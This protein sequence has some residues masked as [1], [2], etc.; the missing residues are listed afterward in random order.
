MMC[1]RALLLGQEA[2]QSWANGNCESAGRSQ[3][4]SSTQP[5]VDQL[6]WPQRISFDDRWHS[7]GA[8]GVGDLWICREFAATEPPR[9]AR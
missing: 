4:S 2:T 6:S 1:A 3:P 7:A 5:R 9:L 8:L